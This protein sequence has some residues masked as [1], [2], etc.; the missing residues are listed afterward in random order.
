MGK[1]NS[2]KRRLD[3]IPQQQTVHHQEDDESRVKDIR[4]KTSQCNGLFMSKIRYGLQLYGKVRLLEED[5]TGG[6]LK[7]IQIVQMTY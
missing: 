2:R 4:I 6:D 5:P 7:A 3:S 1:T